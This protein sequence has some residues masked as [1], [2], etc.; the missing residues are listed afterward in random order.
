MVTVKLEN[1][2]LGKGAKDYAVPI[3]SYEL[4]ALLEIMQEK[5]MGEINQMW[6]GICDSF[7][8]K[9]G[10]TITNKDELKRISDE[11]LEYADSQMPNQV[12][13]LKMYV[14]YFDEWCN[15]FGEKNI[16]PKLKN[17][18][19]QL[20][21]GIKLYERIMDQFNPLEKRY[22]K[23]AKQLGKVKKIEKKHKKTINRVLSDAVTLYNEVD[24]SMAHLKR[25]LLFKTYAFARK[26]KN[27]QS[28]YFS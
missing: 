23:I 11:M 28:Q 5:Y 19:I 20:K 7:G 15:N 16:G 13:K 3:E 1:K 24:S 9:A 4:Y 25:Y 22:N 18:S 10:S 12:T 21:A 8:S 2:D 17:D 6:I 14:H 26:V 27:T